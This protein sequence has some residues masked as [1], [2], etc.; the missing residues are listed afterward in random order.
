MNAK[1]LKPYGKVAIIVKSAICD[2]FEEQLTVI[3][4]EEEEDAAQ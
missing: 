1:Q 3:D 4:A 2:F